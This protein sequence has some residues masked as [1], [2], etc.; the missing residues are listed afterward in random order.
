MEWLWNKIVTAFNEFTQWLFELLQWIPKKIW[1][2]I[3]D[4][5]ASVVELIPVPGFFTSASAA[6]SAIPSSVVFFASKF[7]IAEGILIILSAYLIRFIIR[8][9]PFIG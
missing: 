1:A 9:I 5:L 8:R 3:L 4:A 6:F 7:A 2:E